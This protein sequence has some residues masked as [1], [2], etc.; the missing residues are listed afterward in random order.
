VTQSD[1]PR[2]RPSITA[3][4]RQLILRLAAENPTWGYRRIHGELSGLGHTLASSTVWQTLKA[5]GVE[6]APERSDVTW[7]Q[8]LHSKP[9]SPVTS[10]PSTL[11]H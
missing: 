1:R 4:V 2:G 3:E 8:F 7:S 5:N 11:P 9:L 6:P 10:S